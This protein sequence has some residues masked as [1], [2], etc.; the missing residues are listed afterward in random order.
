M[1]EDKIVTV[2]LGC[3]NRKLKGFVNVDWDKDCKPDIIADLNKKLPFKDNEVD[4]VYC[5]HLIEHVDD[6][7]EFMHEIW[8][9]CKPKAKVHIIAPS[10]YYL[11]WAIQPHHKRFIRPGYFEIWTPPE[12][13]P[14]KNIVENWVKVTKGAKFVTG[15]EESFNEGKEL[16]FFLKVDKEVTK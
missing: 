5:S 2:N 15:Q 4:F 7:L 11:Y 3:G 13:H 16:R 1:K 9:I 12:L 10:C 8:R 14:N 6:I